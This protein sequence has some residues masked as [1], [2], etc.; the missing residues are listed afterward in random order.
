MIGI[1]GGTFD[2]IH[3][4][5]LRPALEVAEL[6]N[7]DELRFIP[8]ANPPHRW[9]PE[10][11]AQHRLEMV[12]LAIKN[13]PVF[14]LDDREYQR[15]GPSY[16]IDT[17]KEIRAEIGLDRPLCLLIGQ[18]ALQ[19]FTQWRDWQGILNLTHLV[20]SRRPGYEL[21]FTD[22]QWMHDILVNNADELKQ[23]PNGMLFFAK[24]TQLAISAT[25]IRNWLKQGSSVQ[26][27]TPAVVNNYLLTHKLYTR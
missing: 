4:G 23:A 20:V 27:L 13:T 12:K 1:I 19:G 24:V 9:Q 11:D 6:L 21:D 10:A 7:L 15:N 3:F 17:L 25:A 16:T 18:D 26:Y 22:N 2:P 14:K 5:H 8:N